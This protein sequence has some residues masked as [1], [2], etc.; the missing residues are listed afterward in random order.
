M[1]CVFHDIEQVGFD[2]IKPGQY[3]VFYGECRV[4]EDRF[5]ADGFVDGADDDGRLEWSRSGDWRSA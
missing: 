2:I 3:A 4:C 1:S 5:E